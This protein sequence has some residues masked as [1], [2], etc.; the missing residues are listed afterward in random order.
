MPPSASPPQPPS[1]PAATSDSSPPATPPSDC[2]CSSS[3]P[4]V[5]T[6]CSSV[7]PSANHPPHDPPS[8][9][10]QFNQISEHKTSK[11]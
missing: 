5:H 9:S 3:A 8:K 2:L 10:N 1:T 7:T 11:Q 4:A 6:A